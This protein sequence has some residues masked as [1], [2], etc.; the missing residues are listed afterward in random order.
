MTDLTA[1]NFAMKKGDTK[2]LQVTVR[3]AVGAAFPI[4]GAT[5]VTWRLARTARSTPALS[6]TLGAGVTITATNAALG[7]VNCGRLDITILHT[8]SEALD[9]EYFH[10]CHLVD[11]TGAHSTIF[12][13][14]ANFTPNLT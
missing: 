11:A 13:G 6:K 9:G 4:V 8:D 5:A 1:Q 7:E 2:T 10:D 3:D 14:R 12:Q